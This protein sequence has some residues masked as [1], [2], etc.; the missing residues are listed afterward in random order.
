M[1][2]P[3]TPLQAWLCAAVREEIRR[4]LGEA[5]E[6][7]QPL[8]SNLNA[9]RAVLSSLLC[10][11]CRLEELDLRPEHFTYQL[12][13]DVATGCAAIGTDPEALALWIVGADG[14]ARLVVQEEILYLRDEVPACLPRIRQDAARRVTELYRRRQLILA[15]DQLSAEL[16]VGATD[17]GRA[18]RRLARLAQQTSGRR[19]RSRGSDTDPGPPRGEP[20]DARGGG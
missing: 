12:H 1:P 14:P 15:L 16:R 2:D 10:G 17:S 7:P 6:R 8:P 18:A 4:G 3:G 13:R 5:P 9:E 20:R 19:A 11:Q